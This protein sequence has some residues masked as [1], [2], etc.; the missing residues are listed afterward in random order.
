MDRRTCLRLVG[1]AGA[2]GLTG[3]LSEE[4]ES[5]DTAP[6]EASP[7]PEDPSTAD[8]ASGS[9]TASTPNGKET[10]TGVRTATPLPRPASTPAPGECDATAPPKP[11]TGEGLP[12]PRE[13]PGRPTEI[14]T[15][16]VGPFLEAYESAHRFN[17]ILA[18]LGADCVEYV[19]VSS[20]GSTATAA[21]GGVTATVET[22]GS[23]TGT[24]C[25]TVTGTDTPTPLPH[26]DL[27]IE[28]A[29]YYVT[30]RFLLREGV[31]VECWD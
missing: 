10:G 16:A 23:Y 18:D 11:S 15:A 14:T 21:E 17:R 9:P 3:C 19:D 1:A 13:Y 2:M 5:A 31:V 12:D 27:A 7:T 30:D 8:P 28:S 4:G 26:A 6:P 22:R 20:Y 24:T 29:R 25:T